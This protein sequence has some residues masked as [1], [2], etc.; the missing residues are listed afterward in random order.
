MIEERWQS[1]AVATGYHISTR[2]TILRWWGDGEEEVLAYLGTDGH[3]HVDLSVETSH[4][5]Y[6]AGEWAR[7]THT[8]LVWQLMVRT[9]FS[10]WKPEFEIYHLD[11]DTTNNAV[12]NLGAQTYDRRF[13]RMRTVGVRDD[14]FMFAFDKRQR[15]RVEIIETGEI[16]MGVQDAANRIGGFPSNISHCLA[17]RLE[18]HKGFHFRWLE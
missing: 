14:G 3:M 9:W 13:Q 1:A 10:N 8:Y 16:C 11:G 7:Q 2:A 6:E 17:G 12:D 5:D 4:Y 15:G 18:S